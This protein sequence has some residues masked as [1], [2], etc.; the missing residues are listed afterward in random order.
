MNI[1]RQLEHQRKTNKKKEEYKYFVG[2]TLKN[3]LTYE[4]GEKIV[5]RIRA[6]YMDDYLDVPYIQYSLISDDGQKEEGHIA[7][8][9]DGWFYIETSISK[10]GFVYLKAQA[11]DASKQIIAG[12]EE[13]NASAGADVD[14]ILCSMKTP[15]DYAEFWRTMREEVESTEPQILFSEKIE[16][17]THPDFEIFDMRIQAPRSEYTSLIVAYPKN[18][19]KGSL[20]LAMLF[21]GYGV[22]PA[23]PWPMDGYLTVHVSA[24]SMPNGESPEFYQ[25]LRAGALK[26]Y[27]Y[28][29]EENKRG[30]TTYFVKMILRDLAALH[31]FKDHELLNKKDYIFVGS[32]Q[33]GMQAINVAAN[34]EKATAVIANVPGFSDVLGETLAGRRKNGMPKG[35]GVAYYDAAV[36]A[37]FIKCPVYIISGLGDTI[38]PPCTQMAL[39]NAIPSQKYI[40]FYQNKTH[41]FTIPWDNHMYVLGDASLADRYS[42]LTAMY[43]DW[44]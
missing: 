18:A 28:N 37:Q 42:D 25:A 20:K 7:K 33:G 27:G 14:K 43:Y 6:K 4:I 15:E 32:S 26:G 21:Q 17:A 11:C 34:F 40:E 24:H 2:T 44:N 19:E 36:A 35:D 10:N 16:D 22:N 38:C 23:T 12:I 8:G 31:F 13:Y 3:P 5:F 41:S 1:Y 29:A 39:F 9:E 30:E